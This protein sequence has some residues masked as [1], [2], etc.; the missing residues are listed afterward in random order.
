M[1]EDS[2]HITLQHIAMFQCSRGV[3]GGFRVLCIP[4]TMQHM[5]MFQCS[6]GVIDGVGVW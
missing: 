4:I 2:L 6:F 1:A 5:T 3:L